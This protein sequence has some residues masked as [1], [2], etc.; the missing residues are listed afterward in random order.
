MKDLLNGKRV[1]KKEICEALYFFLEERRIRKY[2][3]F[4]ED[5]NRIMNGKVRE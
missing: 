3:Y 5:N 4:Y 2:F 1:F